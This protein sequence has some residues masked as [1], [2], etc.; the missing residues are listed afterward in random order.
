MVLVKRSAWAVVVAKQAREGRQSNLP[1]F[2]FGRLDMRLNNDHT[3][4][5][6]TTGDTTMTQHTPGPWNVDNRH[7]GDINGPDGKDPAE[8]LRHAR[9]ITAAPDL[10]A[11]LRN[12]ADAGVSKWDPSVRD[13]FREWAQSRARAAIAKATGQ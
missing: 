9:L 5:T 1:A 13:Q 7:F 2:L 10:L 3:S 12:I 11:E 6:F 8:E 4:R